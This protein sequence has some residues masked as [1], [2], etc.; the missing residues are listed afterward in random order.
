LLDPCAAIGWGNF[1]VPP[2]HRATSS[3][4]EMNTIFYALTQQSRGVGAGRKFDAH[5]VSSVARQ[6]VTES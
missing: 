6:K 4:V 1:G 5:P 3:E 2:S